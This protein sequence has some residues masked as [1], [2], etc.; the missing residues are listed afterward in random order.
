MRLAERPEREVTV[1]AGVR[2][3]SVLHTLAP[4]LYELLVSRQVVEKN[5]LRSEHAPSTSGNL[6]EPDATWSGVSGGYKVKRKGLLRRALGA[7]AFLSA[8]A[9]AWLIWLRTR[10]GSP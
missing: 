5:L 2:V 4:A 9:A 7:S 3:L 1:G 10:G 8:P 6:F